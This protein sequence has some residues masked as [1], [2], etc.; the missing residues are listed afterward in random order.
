MNEK[1]LNRSEALR[2]MG[3]RG[4]P[5]GAF[6]EVL[7]K[8]EKD[9]AAAAR[10]KYICKVLDAGDFSD[11]LIGDDI[12]RH[13]EGCSQVILFAATLGVGVDAL[14]RKY[15]VGDMTSALAADAVA[16]AFTEEYCKEVDSLLA[17]KFEGA[18]LTWRFSPGYGD[19]PIELQ[20]DF[21]K[22][23]DA[24]RKIGLSV[25]E[26]HMLS[27]SK[28]V[29]AVIGVSDRE[30]SKERQNCAACKMADRCAFRRE[31]AHC[32]F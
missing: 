11:F 26:S 30:I 21:I 12:V 29:T 22:A 3:Y 27:P 7:E 31:G 9:V 16:S 8:C 1:Y 15:Q 13:I 20:D 6:L 4:E 14:I 23:V 32:G 5:E 28:S 18:H 10:P 24:Y 25:T 17:E 2:Y 19:F